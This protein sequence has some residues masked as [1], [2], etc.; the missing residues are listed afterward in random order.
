MSLEPN[1]KI[2]S[3]V[4]CAPLPC[5]YKNPS[6]NANTIDQS[7]FQIN[8]AKEWT[9]LRT[10][11]NFSLITK[12]LFWSHRPDGTLGALTLCLTLLLNTG[13]YLYNERSNLFP[14]F[15]TLN[16]T[17]VRQINNEVDKRS[18]CHSSS[19]PLCAF[20]LSGH[21]DLGSQLDS[22]TSQTYIAKTVRNSSKSGDVSN[23]N[24]FISPLKFDKKRH[25][26]QI[27]YLTWSR[28]TVRQQVAILFT[29]KDVSYL[30]D[31]TALQ[32]P[33]GRSFQDKILTVFE[34]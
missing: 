14:E 30:S 10:I 8:K 34:L 7:V 1:Q 25:K 21:D 28:A 22:H 18:Q 33:V 19:F 31:V 29:D 5:V 3:G 6:L 24:A 17:Q 16:I 11:N 26:L 15:Q 4:L 12:D 13:Y 20:G 2:R 32:A 9:K 27:L 23:F